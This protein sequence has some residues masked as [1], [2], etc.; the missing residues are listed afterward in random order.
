LPIIALYALAGYRLMP[1]IQQIYASITQ[2]KFV[3]DAISTIFTDLSETEKNLIRSA[4]DNQIVTKRIEL[5]EKIF[6]KNINFSHRNTTNIFNGLTMEIK[7]KKISAIV[8]Q[9][10]SGKTTLTDIVAGLLNPSQGSIFIDQ[11]ELNQDNKKAWQQ[12]IGYL[13]QDIYLTDNTIEQNIAFGID[14]ADINQK[15][16][17][18]AAKLANLH[19]YIMSLPNKYQTIVGERGVRISGGQKQRIA[20]ARAI[21]NE[22][23]V[24]ILDEGTSALDT[25]TE[26]SVI[27]SLESLSRNMTIIMVAHKM[28]TIKKADEIFLFDKGHLVANGSYSFLKNNSEL[29]NSLIGGK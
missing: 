21:Y 28:E 22:P 16:I 10:G 25:I 13:P 6:L 9:S 29:F 26:N 20:I 8:G 4:I 27:E 18:K 17:I 15:L 11:I 24:L 2:I 12:N 1:A 5:K 23:S 7:A 19:E 3:G 14:T